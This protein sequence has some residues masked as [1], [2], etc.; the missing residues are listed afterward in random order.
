VKAARARHP[1]PAPG[2]CAAVS[3]FLH[4]R[5]RLL[6]GPRSGGCASCPSS[7]LKWEMSIWDCADAALTPYRMNMRANWNVLRG[8]TGE[9]EASVRAAA[10]H[11]HG[12]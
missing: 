1:G 9:V 10:G 7:I 11:G 5:T 8:L 4:R 3:A 6:E 2:T 12:P